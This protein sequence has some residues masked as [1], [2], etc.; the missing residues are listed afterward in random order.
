MY[1]LF[2]QNSSHVEN[3]DICKIYDNLFDNQLVITPALHIPLPTGEFIL[4]SEWV[5]LIALWKFISSAIPADLF[6]NQVANSPAPHIALPTG[7]RL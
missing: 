4:K 1:T 5:A 2:S 6:D 7:V 3:Y